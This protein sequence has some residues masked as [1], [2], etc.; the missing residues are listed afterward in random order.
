[1]DQTGILF[2]PMNIF[3]RLPLA[4]Q[5]PALSV[6]C[7]AFFTNAHADP[8]IVDYGPS[9]GYVETDTSFARTAGS[10][11]SA[12]FVFR[13]NFSDQAGDPLSPVSGY[14]GPVFYGGYQF[15]SSDINQGFHRQQIR[16]NFG[17]PPVD[18][19]FLQSYRE[20]GWEGSTLSL[21][22]VYL[23]Q[24]TDFLNG[25]DSGAVTL[26]YLAVTYSG[27]LAS[28][29]P[30]VSFH[31]RFVVRV[32]GLYYVSKT[33]FDF[34]SP[35]GTAVLEEADLSSETWAVYEPLANL[36]FE[37][38]GA[39]F[40]PLSLDEVTAVG[41]YFEEDEWEGTSSQYAAYGLGIRSFE[42]HG[43][44]TPR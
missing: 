30:E 22:G 36:N 10:S 39:T 23:F 44:P 41:V 19:I 20:E 27:F 26:S 18:Q 7:L 28:A 42:A 24:Q 8:S 5:I 40:S 25:M 16:H 34:L 9:D 31:G 32:G 15:I 33:T 37:Q 11:G 12:P 4:P 1:M 43:R 3:M 21:H 38:D 13:R 29:N 17:T 2:S 35:N 6:C 14:K